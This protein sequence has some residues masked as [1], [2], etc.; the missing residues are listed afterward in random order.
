MLHKAKKQNPEAIVVAVGC[1]VQGAKEELNKDLSVDIIIGNNRKK[2][3]LQI[4]EQTETKEELIDISK[5]HEYEEL[6]INKSSEHIRVNIKIQDGCNQFC[7]YCIIPYTRGRV[8]SRKPEEVIRE[9][10][11]IA[12]KGCKEVVLTGIHTASYGVD[13]ED[14]MNLLML[15][16]EIDNIEGIERIRLSSLEQGIITEDFA[17]GVSSLKKVCP[18]FHLSL[19]SGSDETLKR[20]NRKYNTDEFYKKTEILRRYFENPGITTDIIVGFSGETDE[21][22][23]ETKRFVE[24]VGFSGIHVFKYSKKKGQRRLR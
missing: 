8:R 15:I 17:R 7:S 6:Q 13:F 24:K 19:Q 22:F 9:T 23:E 3:L 16:Q 5:T 18:H 4:I 10:Q 12:E 14:D 11:R 20:M 2:D 21:E 1:Y